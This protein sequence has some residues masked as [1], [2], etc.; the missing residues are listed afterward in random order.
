[1]LS[2]SFNFVDVVLTLRWFGKR[3]VPIFLQSL[4]CEVLEEVLE[5]SARFLWSEDS[6]AIN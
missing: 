6:V 3:G 1:M 5:S 2:V 4:V